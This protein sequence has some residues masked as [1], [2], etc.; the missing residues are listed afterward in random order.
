MA[1]GTVGGALRAHPAARLALAITGV[2]GAREFA[3][4]V[5]AAGLAS[6]L[7]A[8]RALATEGIQKG[9]MALHA[10]AIARE[11]G[12]TGPAVEHVAEQLAALGDVTPERA[13]LLLSA[14]APFPMEVSK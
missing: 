3:G 9:H 8:I 13:R 12:A 11:A 1:V 2:T 6:N 5:A 14:L 4:V 10:R 7:A